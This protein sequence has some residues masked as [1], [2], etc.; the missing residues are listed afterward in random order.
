MG[1]EVALR[2]CGLGGVLIREATG[3]TRIAVRFVPRRIGKAWSDESARLLFAQGRADR[4][5]IERR[6]RNM[7]KARRGTLSG[8]AAVGAEPGT[9]SPRGSVA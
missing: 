1:F 3:W 8:A 4:A 5:F 6:R 9:A 7:P 2:V